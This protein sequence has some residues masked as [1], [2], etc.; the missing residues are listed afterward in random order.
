MSDLINETTK[1]T[2]AEFMQREESNLPIELLDGEIIMRPTPRFQHQRILGNLFMLLK[3]LLKGGHLLYAPMDM[4]LSE[5]DSVQPDLFWVAPDN[6]ACQLVEGYWY[7]PPTLVIE[8][9]SPSTALRDRREKYELYEQAEVR[10]YWLVD[11]DARMVEVYRL[12]EGRFTR[13]GVF[14]AEDGILSPLFEQPLILVPVFELP[15]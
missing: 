14:G 8:I 9:L 12:G 2:V 10:E 6:T 15:S 7:G 3:S 11:P 5:Y 1:L 13:Q 4:H